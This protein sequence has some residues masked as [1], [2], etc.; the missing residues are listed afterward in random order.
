MQGPCVHNA[1]EQY[2]YKLKKSKFRITV[3]I[4]H[5]QNI[6][7]MKKKNVLHISGYIIQE[8]SANYGGIEYKLFV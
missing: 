6:N 1:H 2:I 7:I 8:A 3:V 4:H 5:K